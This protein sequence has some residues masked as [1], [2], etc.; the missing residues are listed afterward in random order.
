MADRYAAWARDPRVRAVVVRGAGG[1]AFCAGGDVKAL[2]GAVRAGKPAAAVAFF[3][4]EVTL[5][6]YIHSLRPSLPQVALLDGYTMGGGAGLA[7]HGEFRVATEATVFSMPENAIGL[8]PDVGTTYFL[9]R[10]P[11]GV[12]PWLGITGARLVGADVV[13]AGLASHYVP[14]AGLGALCAALAAITAPRGPAAVAAVRAVLD[15]AAVPT[16]DLPPGDLEAV[17]PQ[18]DAVFGDWRGAGVTVAAFKA[19]VAAL[20]PTPW[21]RATAAALA[22][23]CPQSQALTLALLRAGAAAPALGAALRLEFRALLTALRPDTDFVEGVTA[24]LFEKRAPVWRGGDDDAAIA[25]RLAPP[26]AEE[27]L[28]LGATASGGGARPRL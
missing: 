25:A 18:V 5:F 3:R 2:V 24:R 4:T 14:A 27:E 11:G 7:L 15:A 20:P 22:A 26:G 28:E 12:G 17:R 1:K 13:R 9:P 10:L 21:T 19:R 23:D 8:F 16:A 6:H